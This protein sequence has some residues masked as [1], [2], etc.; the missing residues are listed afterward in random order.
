M[1]HINLSLK[2]PE[3]NKFAITSYLYYYL[4]G[5]LS[6]AVYDAIDI[7]FYNKTK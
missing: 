4:Q 7:P 1:I 3:D 5:I 6:T 2:L